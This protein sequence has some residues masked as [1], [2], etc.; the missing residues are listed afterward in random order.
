MFEGGL[1]GPAYVH[2]GSNTFWFS[3][4]LLA[5]DLNIGALTVSN[6][7]NTG[8]QATGMAL[9]TLTEMYSG[10]PMPQATPSTTSSPDGGA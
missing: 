5:P 4:T 8:Q 1:D 2:D 9:E 6:E 7:A 3:L 10:E